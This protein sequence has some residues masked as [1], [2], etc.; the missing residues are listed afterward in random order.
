M[1]YSRIDVKDPIF[2]EWLRWGNFIVMTVVLIVMH[3]YTKDRE[4]KMEESKE[5]I[6]S[7]SLSINHMRKDKGNWRRI[8]KFIKK[9][10]KDKQIKMDEKDLV[11]IVPYNIDHPDLS[12]ASNR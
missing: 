11:E 4:K 9:I 12:H 5:Q 6:S 1:Y 10:M 2:E 3:K 8:I 7:Y